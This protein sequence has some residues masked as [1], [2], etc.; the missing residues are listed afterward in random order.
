MYEGFQR[1]FFKFAMTAFLMA[2]LASKGGVGLAQAKPA[3]V[4]DAEIEAS[5]LKALAGAP[6]LADQAITSTTVYGV[7]T[8][9]GTVRD[10]PSRDLADHVVSNTAGVQKVV[11]QLVVGAVPAATDNSSQQQQDSSQGT[12]PNLQSDGSVAPPQAQSTPS[13]NSPSAPAAPQ[14]S[15]QASPYPPPYQ[16]QQGGQNPPPYQGQQGG[17]YPPAYGG[18]G[19]QYPPPYPGQQQPGQ[20]PAYGQPYPSQY[21]P[22][23]PYVAQKGGDAVVVPI[24]ANLRVRINQ[25]LN[26]KST[27]VGTSFDGVVLN[28]VVA[29]NSI[30]I[31]RGA[32]IQGTVVGVHTAGELKGKGEL[33]LQ[34]NSVS[35]GGRVYPIATD[36]WWHQGVDKTGNTVG[37]TVGLGAVGALIG[38]VAGGG[39]GAAVGAGVGGVAGLGVSAASG[40]GEAELPPEAILVFHLTQP[41]D[42][43][44]VSQ[45]ELNRLGAGVPVGADP[46]FRRRYPP[47]PPPGYYGPGYYRPY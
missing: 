43:T 28:D 5:V 14:G 45:A 31:P 10:E 27:T 30:A 9:S 3:T 1:K 39:V 24:G 12:N 18:Q 33:K 6:E 22:Q 36:F 38:A 20:Y 26:S 15:Q 2:S 34:L 32:S 46:Q 44:T 37:N 41:A 4:P 21:P 35:L 13:P 23:R 11:D 47:P 19:G 16:G 42:I 40:R 25:G 7:V 29:G 17:Q 8:L